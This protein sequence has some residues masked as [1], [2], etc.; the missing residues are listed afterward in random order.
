M[1]AARLEGRPHRPG[2]IAVGLSEFEKERL[3]TD[4]LVYEGQ[5]HW[6]HYRHIEQER[7]Q[8]LGFFF[9]LLVGIV[10][11]FVALSTRVPSWPAL[12]LSLSTM[13]AALGVISFLIFASVRKFGVALHTYDRDIQRIR[14]ALL[15]RAEPGRT[16]LASEHR[17][18]AMSLR[19]S[20]LH[21]VFDPQ[22]AAEVIVGTS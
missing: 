14:A 9:T 1:A 3:L 12:A 19:P 7:N 11:F 13:A 10:G 20:T 21:Q 15:A 4:A 8:F 16:H 22:F 18:F 2:V 5:Q 17:T 6:L